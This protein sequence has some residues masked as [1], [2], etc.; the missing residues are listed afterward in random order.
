MHTSWLTLPHVYDKWLIDSLMMI[1]MIDAT[2]HY[3][4]RLTMMVVVVLFLP[5]S[6]LKVKIP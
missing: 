1:R 2:L 4:V 6:Y 5:L 3:H